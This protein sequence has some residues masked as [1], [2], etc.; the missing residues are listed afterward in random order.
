MTPHER[1]PSSSPAVLWPR[2]S[3]VYGCTG[4]TAGPYDACPAHLRPEQLERFLGG[5]RPGA[6]LDLRGATVP[7][8]LLAALLDAVTGPD[9]RPHLGRARFDGAVVHADAPLRA[10][11]FEGDSSFD[12]ACFI[13][14]ASFFD[15]RFFGNVSFRGARFAGNATFHGARFH[16]HASFEE[17]VFAGDALFGEAAWHADASFAHAV[18]MGAAC[19]DRARFGRDAGMQAV[20]FGGAVSFRRVQVT[21]H[22]RFERTRFRHDLWL[23][24][25]VARRID[26]A[27][28]H[29]HGGLRVDAAALEVTAQAMTV[30]AAA[31]FK[32][33]H[34][35][36][37][38][39][40]SS[41]K[42]AVRVRPHTHPFQGLPEPASWDGDDT[43]RVNSLRGVTAERLD[44][45]DV[46]LSRCQFI[47]LQRPDHLRIVEGCSFATTPRTRRWLP[48]RAPKSRAVLAED[49]GTRVPLHGPLEDPVGA[50]R[51]ETLYRQLAQATADS[52]G[53]LARDFRYC[54]LEMHRRAEPVQWRRWGLHLLW[55]TCGYG[56]RTGRLFV[57]LAVVAVLVCGTVTIARSGRNPVAAHPGTH[58]H[59]H[60]LV[61][62]H[63]RGHVRA[64]A[65]AQDGT[66][67]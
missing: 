48:W 46:D 12:G 32:L 23:G 55:I 4:R 17:T 51:L 15:V 11:C 60:D 59:T 63:V 57:W 14:G 47:G 33:R 22:L 21:R 36:L 9:K 43:V 52:D 54:A 30:R 24:P 50:A 7:P 8:G 56:L 35:E 66:T 3:V 40:N 45:A 26:L 62:A 41:F 13:G 44:L 37:D 65:P 6:E 19:F 16:R 2:C 38:L 34:T 29:A 27:H 39:E 61:R 64:H 5:L 42:G 1:A 67:P 20:C 25:L 49:P 58:M 18:F 10:A 28:V 31:E 53:G